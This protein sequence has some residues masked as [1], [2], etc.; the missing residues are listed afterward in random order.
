MKLFTDSWQISHS[1]VLIALFMSIFPLET[2]ALKQMQ[3]ETEAILKDCWFSMSTP[4]LWRLLGES[5]VRWKPTEGSGFCIFQ[6]AAGVLLTGKARALPGPVTGR[7]GQCPKL[8]LVFW[9]SDTIWCWL[10]MRREELLRANYRFLSLGEQ[11]IGKAIKSQWRRD[12]VETWWGR[13]VMDSG[14]DSSECSAGDI[15]AT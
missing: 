5:R 1:M 8:G 2:E 11:G 13:D 3:D 4:V 14:K 12:Q 9:L 15:L 10:G 6:Q 7:V